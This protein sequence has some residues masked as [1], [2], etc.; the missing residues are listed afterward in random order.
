M[1]YMFQIKIK[2][3]SYSWYYKMIG[4]NKKRKMYLSPRTSSAEV[5]LEGLVCFS[6]NKTLN[7]DQLHNINADETASQSEV[8]YFEF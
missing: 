2:P 1:R 4:L 5:D 7:V 6:G 8:L 3:N